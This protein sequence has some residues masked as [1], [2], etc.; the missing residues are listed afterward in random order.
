MVSIKDVAKLAGVSVA[1]VSRTL[2]KPEAVAESTREQVMAAVAESGYVANALARNFRRR[3]SHTVVVLM[4]DIGNPFYALVVQGIEQAAVQAGYQVLLGDTQNDEEREQA[5]TELVRQR[6]ADGLICLGPHIPFDIDESLTTAPADWPPLVMACE[7]HGKVKL[8]RIVIDNEQA[9]REMTE[10]L[11]NQGHQHIAFIN[12]PE[13]SPLC[14]AR[15]DGYL[16]VLIDSGNTFNQALLKHGDFSMESGYELAKQLLQS[17]Q[18][19]TA[20]FCAND[21]MAIGALHAVRDANLSV[22]EDIAIAGFDDINIAKFSYPPLTTVHQPRREIGAKA[23]QLLLQ[24]LDG[25]NSSETIVLPHDLI[26]RKST[27][28]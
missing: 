15:F 22:P 11:I 4:P 16:Q 19:P 5:Y 3:R 8:P 13:E 27:Q 26:I 21:E 23:M 9:A 1:T 25:G 17:T 28:Q 20:I 18:K 24:L 7:Y 10:H 12:G 6:T 2:S 14:Q